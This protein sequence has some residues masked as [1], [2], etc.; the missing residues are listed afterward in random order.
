M[1]QG[2]LDFIVQLTVHEAQD[3]AASR[4]PC[5][6]AQWPVRVQ[7]SSSMLLPTR[8]KLEML[9]DALQ[10]CSAERRDRLG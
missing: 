1:C 4:E 7:R 3:V 5:R 8:D 9:A 10:R 2:G 6:L